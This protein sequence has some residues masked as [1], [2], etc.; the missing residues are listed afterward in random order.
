[1][2]I[3]I[4]VLPLLSLVGLVIRDAPG[5]I[6]SEEGADIAVKLLEVGEAAFGLTPSSGLTIPLDAAQAHVAKAAAHLANSGAH[7]DKLNVLQQ[8]A[9]LF[10]P[11]G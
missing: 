2:H 9:G 10:A 1:M 7:P 3:Q 5:G 11:K 8:L 4:P 6:T